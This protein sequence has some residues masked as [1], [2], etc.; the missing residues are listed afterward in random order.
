MIEYPDRIKVYRN[1]E[2][3]IEYPLKSRDVKYEQVK[4]DGCPMK[5]KPQHSHLTSEPEEAKLRQIYGEIMSC[6]LDF[7]RSKDG[8][9]RYRN[10]FVKNL[11]SLS[12]RIAPG[13]F[14]KAIERALAYN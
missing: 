12:L 7:I 10:P 14:A 1:R 5:R 11:Y 6:Y 8:V 3:L 2:L 13:V 9:V 4:P